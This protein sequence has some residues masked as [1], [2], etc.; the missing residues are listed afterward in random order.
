MRN[1]P[2]E[3]ESPFRSNGRKVDRCSYVRS[4]LSLPDQFNMAVFVFISL[5]SR[6]VVAIEHRASYNLEN[7]LLLTNN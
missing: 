4:A 7:T 5:C 2:V 3:D 6:A 1:K